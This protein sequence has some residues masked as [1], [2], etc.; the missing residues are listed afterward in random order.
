[1]TVEEVNKKFDRQIKH[2]LYSKWKIEKCPSYWNK[3]LFNLTATLTIDDWRIIRTEDFWKAKSGA[4][5]EIES[6]RISISRIEA[7][8]SYRNQ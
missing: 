4:E 7:Y 8:L 1:M 3:K 6:I 2:E 5:S